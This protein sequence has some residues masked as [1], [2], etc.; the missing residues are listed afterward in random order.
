MRE[1]RPPSEPCPWSSS[2]RSSATAHYPG[3]TR[4]P[5]WSRGSA[6]WSRRTPAKGPQPLQARTRRLRQQR[7]SALPLPQ[8]LQRRPRPRQQQRRQR[9]L[10]QRRHLE[11]Q[12]QRP[13]RMLP[14]LLRHRRRRHRPRTCRPWR[15]PLATRWSC[16]LVRCLLAPCRTQGCGRR[17]PQGCH[18][19]LACHLAFHLACHLQ[20]M[21]RRMQLPS[22]SS[23]PSQ[24]MRRRN[25]QQAA[26]PLRP[27]RGSRQVHCRQVSRCLQAW[28]R[29]RM[30]WCLACL[31]RQATRQCQ[32]QG[33]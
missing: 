27:P 18:L 7:Q 15:C 17:R 13:R 33:R 22:N 24:R 32:C 10:R 3:R 1:R 19:H 20:V 31:R 9:Q 23:R 25:R 26:Q 8:V 16:H 5:C 12:R 11:R 28:S 30:V 2:R 29:R 6:R 14:P 4:R 21:L